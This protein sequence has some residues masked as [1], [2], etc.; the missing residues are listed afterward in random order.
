VLIGFD[1]TAATADVQL[2]VNLAVALQREEVLVAIDDG[3]APLT[4]D[5]S[6]RYGP[7]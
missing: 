1:I 3:D 7:R 4:L 2:D 6:G 5:I